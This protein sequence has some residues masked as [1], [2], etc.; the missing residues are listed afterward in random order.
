MIGGILFGGAN[1]SVAA[2]ALATADFG[3]DF[4]GSLDWGG[5]TSVVNARTGLPLTG[6]TVTSKSGFD[7][8]QVFPRVPEPSSLAL[9]FTVLA[10]CAARRRRLSNGSTMKYSS[11]QTAAP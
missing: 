3:G 1:F 11:P 10:G 7:Y 4:T 5:I 6:W 8:S 9:L 2:G